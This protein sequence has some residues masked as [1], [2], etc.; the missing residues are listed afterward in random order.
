MEITVILIIVYIFF[1]FSSRKESNAFDEAL[2]SRLKSEP[3]FFEDKESSR[4]KSTYKP[5]TYRNPFVQPTGT[6]PHFG[7][8]LMSAEAK[9]Q[10]LQSPEWKALKQ[11][12]LWRAGN[13]CQLCK[14]TTNLH[15]HHLTY[16]RL[17]NELL[18]DLVLLCSVC[19]QAQHD[20][21]GY[22]RLTDYSILIKPKQ[23]E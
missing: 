10:Y 5:T 17:G 11:A 22:S 13:K 3:Y 6:M 9:H 14:S 20:H 8:P 1:Y 21:Y 19:H 2:K 4:P 7:N 12:K 16:D 23:S 15:L 18:T